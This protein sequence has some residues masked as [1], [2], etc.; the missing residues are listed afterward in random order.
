MHKF[1]R[2][3]GL[4]LLLSML[5]LVLQACDNEEEDEPVGVV[6]SQGLQVGQTAPA[7]SLPSVDGG[8]VSLSDYVGNQPV[9]LYFHMAVG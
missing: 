7:F 9:L 6:T 8:E 3:F 2:L 5:G 4:A 1:F